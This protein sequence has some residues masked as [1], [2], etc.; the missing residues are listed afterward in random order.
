M[1]TGPCAR[2]RAVVRGTSP[3]R[4]GDYRLHVRYGDDVHIVDDPYRY[5]PTLGE[6]DLH[7]IGEGRHER[8]WTVLGA[9]V[10]TYDSPVGDGDRASASRSGRRAPRACAWSATSTGWGAHDGWPMRSMGGSGVWE[11]FVPDVAPAAR[12]TSSGSSAGTA[13]G[14]RRPTRWP[15]HAEV[16]AVDRVGRLRSRPR[17]GDD[18]WL[19]T[20]AARHAA[21][22]SR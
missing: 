12:G 4:R 3:R 5:L 9:H 2:R 14:G 13:C 20:R 16:P 6:I 7:L 15:S 18:E 17:R 22:P 8:L 11:L 10:R 21:P 1:P 19:A